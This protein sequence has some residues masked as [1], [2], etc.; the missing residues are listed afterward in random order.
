[1][2]DKRRGR[3]TSERRARDDAISYAA[4]RI[5][6]RPLQ[7]R[8]SA[9][10]RAWPSSTPSW[11]RSAY[12]TDRTTAARR[13]AG[14]ARQPHRRSASSGRACATARNEHGNYAPPDYKPVNKPLIVALPG[15]TMNDPNR[16]QPLAL[17]ELG[18]PERPPAAGQARRSVVGPHWGHVTPFALPAGRRP[19]C[20]ST[21][22]RR[23]CLHDPTADAAFKDAAVEVIRLSSQLDPT[24]GKVIDISPGAHRATTRLAPTTAHGHEV[25]PVTGAALR[26]DD[27]PAR[28]LRPRARRVLGRRPALGDAARPL[29]HDRQLRRRLAL[30]SSGRIGGS[31]EELDPLEW[32]VKMYLALNGAVHDAAVAA[33]GRQGLLRLG[34]AD[35]DDPLHGRPRP[36]ERSRRARPT[37]PM[38]CPSCPA[39]SRSSPRS[40]QRAGRAP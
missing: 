13:L 11:P 23:R 7:A 16:W 22:A 10:R 3:R 21:R 14:R 32:D 12:P 26:A 6:S 36:V 40:R 27:R 1:M 17:E 33:W 4:Y 5:L 25:N 15:T 18:R 8:P 34:A 31:G 30:A 39:S 9:P 24:D 28:R 35:L 20:P 2:T 19:A 38:A 29:E 37:T